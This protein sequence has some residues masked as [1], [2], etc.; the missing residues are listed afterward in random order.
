MICCIFNLNKVDHSSPYYRVRKRRFTANKHTTKQRHRLDILKCILVSTLDFLPSLTVYVSF[1]VNVNVQPYIE[2]KL[3]VVV[4][5]PQLC[6]SPFTYRCNCGTQMITSWNGNIFHVIGRVPGICRGLVNSS[7][8]G[9][10]HGILMFSLICAWT[11][12]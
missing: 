2:S 5:R 3:A 7:H 9:Q 10:W 11:H 8:K 1:T 6:P 4:S 12:V